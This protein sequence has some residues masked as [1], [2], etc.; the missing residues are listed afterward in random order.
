MKTST[1]PLQPWHYYHIYNRGINGCT[2]FKKEKHYTHFLSKYAY[3]VSPF[4][5][6]FAYSLLG[7][8]FHLLIQVKSEE[9]ILKSAEDRYSGKEIASIEKLISSQFAHLFNGYSQSFNKDENRTGGLFESPFRRIKV[10][11]DAYFS[12]LVSYIHLNP[13]KHG[14]IDDFKNYPHSSYR[15]HLSKSIT[16]LKQKQV[17]E[18]FGGIDG[19]IQFHESQRDKSSTIPKFI[20]E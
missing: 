3:H 14:L 7:N 20:M 11:D 2:I 18:W 1:S 5:D 8:H 15:S 10:D 16:R 9:E 13:E 12:Q 6:T 17:L 19:Y 4:V